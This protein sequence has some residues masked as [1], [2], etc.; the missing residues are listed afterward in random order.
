VTVDVNVPFIFTLVPI[1]NFATAALTKWRVSNRKV[2]YW[3]T[4]LSVRVGF[5]AASQGHSVAFQDVL[6]RG[7]VKPKF[8]SNGISAHPSSIERGRRVHRYN[9][10]NNFW[11]VLF[12]GHSLEEGF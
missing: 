12:H 9:F 7:S 3:F 2:L 6:N 4:H 5:F 1:N 8:F 11:W 10:F